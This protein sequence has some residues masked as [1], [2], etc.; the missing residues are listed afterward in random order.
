MDKLEIEVQYFNGCLHSKDF[1]EIVR[2]ALTKVESG[3]TYKETLVDTF[4]K[5][6]EVNFRGS[7]TLLINGTDVE[8]TEPP[9]EPGL[10]CRVYRNGLPTE[11]Q[12]AERLRAAI[13]HS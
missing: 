10:N 1:I 6:R 5:A 2:R 3:Y 8:N 4:E 11:D 7:P 12:I 13:R 9:Q